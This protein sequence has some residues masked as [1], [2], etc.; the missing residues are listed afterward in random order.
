[1][2]AVL[3]E[4]MAGIVTALW[5]GVL[6]TITLVLTMTLDGRSG[7]GF[8]FV[9]FWAAGR[10][11]WL[12]LGGL[13]YQPALHRLVEITVSPAPML[14]QFVYPPPFM[15]LCAPLG[16]L[17]FIPALVVFL[18]ASYAALV[19]ALRSATR[20]PWAMLATIS[21]PAVLADLLLGQ[22]AILVAAILGGGLAAIDRHP[23]RAGILL[24][25]LIIKPN[26]TLA[27]PAML[28]LTRRWRVLAYAALSCLAL[29]A[30]ATL[31][32]GPAI[33]GSFLATTATV[34][35]WIASGMLDFNKLQSIYALVR[36]IGFGNGTG[37][38]IQ[39]IA[40]GYALVMLGL[41][42]RR[43]GTLA[44]VNAATVLAGIVITPYVMTYD[45][46]ITVMPIVVLA[47]AWQRTGFPPGGKLLLFALWLL[48]LSL[49]AAPAAHLS[50]LGLAATL[51]YLAWQPAHAK[52]NTGHGG[53][54]DR[55][56]NGWPKSAP[57]SSHPPMRPASMHNAAGEPS[58][59]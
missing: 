29:C 55:Q 54:H 56:R 48:P 16:G 44:E 35:H 36:R 42:V 17:A 12:G 28:L 33:W 21:A 19:L 20:R 45:L 1:M 41:V 3:T 50:L 46:A 2:R 9:N 8:D 39:A 26:L 52:P 11:I 22:S 57:P 24:G 23:R 49:L 40:A 4:R 5:V 43:G 27:V 51:A 25:L 31:A 58:G 6:G 18:T 59:C 53:R 14:L 47:C 13:V 15:L 32:F 37:Y 30:A 34:G 7:F 10:M 38:A